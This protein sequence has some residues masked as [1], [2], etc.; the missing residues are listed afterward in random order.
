METLLSIFAEIDDPRDHTAQYPLSAMLFI[1]LAATLC[2]AQA[3][4]EMADYAE[5]NLAD[6][7]EIVALP[8]RALRHDSLA[9]CFA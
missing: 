9:G 4:T 8:G 7:S 5:A 2:G 3:C 1:A 6:L